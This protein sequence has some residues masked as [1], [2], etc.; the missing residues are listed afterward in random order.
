[1]KAL[2]A[3]EAL[4]FVDE[5]REIRLRNPFGVLV[6]LLGS[7]VIEPRLPHEKIAAVIKF[8]GETTKPQEVR[9]AGMEVTLDL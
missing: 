5:D 2:E 6:L 4:K 7:D 8:L 9:R 1:M 3:I